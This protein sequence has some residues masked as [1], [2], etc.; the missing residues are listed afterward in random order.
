MLLDQLSPTARSP[1]QATK[2]E[3]K[4]GSPMQFL[5]KGTIYYTSVRFVQNSKYLILKIAIFTSSL[6]LFSFSF[7]F[8]SFLAFCFDQALFFMNFLLPS[9]SV[10]SF[11]ARLLARYW[12]SEISSLLISS[13]VFSISLSF[14]S[15]LW[16]ISFHTP[17][18]CFYL[19][20]SKIF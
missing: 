16:E 17:G 4:S 9:F 14:Y 8:F 2:R 7:F 3:R 12:I 15:T 6:F 20:I 10:F 18:K 19:P 5:L 13:F 1:T 11:L